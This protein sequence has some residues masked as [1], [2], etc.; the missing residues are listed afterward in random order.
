MS[1]FWAGWMWGCAASVIINFAIIW[2]R[3][4]CEI[5]RRDHAKEGEHE[6]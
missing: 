6:G 4:R 3:D 5:R 2:W 1:D